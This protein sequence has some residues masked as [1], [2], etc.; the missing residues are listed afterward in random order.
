MTKVT[1]E[2]R[3]SKNTLYKQCLCAALVNTCV[4]DDD[5][6]TLDNIIN[7]YL[8][9][10]GLVRQISELLNLELDLEKAGQISLKWFSDNEERK[11][12]EFLS[13][14]LPE[15]GYNNGVS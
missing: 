4:N 10:S 11:Q 3:I 7:I 5:L 14:I 2:P 8:S 15:E 1:M 12:R 9:Y 6:L 13:S